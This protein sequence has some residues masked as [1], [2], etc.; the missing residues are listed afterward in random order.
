MQLSPQQLSV[1]QAPDY[2]SGKTVMITGAG[3]DLGAAISLECA[4][5]GAT[6]VLMDTKQRFLNPIYDEILNQ[7]GPEPIIAPFDLGKDENSPQAVAH[8]IAAAVSRL[9]CL[10]HAHTVAAPL[11]PMNANKIDTW[12]KYF[13]TV[14][15]LPLQLTQHLLG[16]LSTTQNGSVLFLSA[17]VGRVPRAY[18]GPVGS[19]YAAL[20]NTVSTWA[21]EPGDTGVLFN[22]ID[23][24]KVKTALRKKYYPAEA[25]N[26]LRT[27]DDPQ[28]LAHFVYLA[29]G[30]DHQ[31]QGQK[32]TVPDL[33]V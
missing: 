27:V 19:A 15:W 16:T 24:G 32:I 13:K 12:E 7:G 1:A 29:N 25:S 20:E 8:T 11:T 9:D 33:V 22:T 30:D 26:H 3:S 28:L 10:I 23:P 17:D 4:K 31:L 5:K 6:I 2:L 18:W 21:D 14:V